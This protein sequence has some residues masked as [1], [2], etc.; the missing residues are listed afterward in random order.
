MAS[1]N[2]ALEWFIS[3]PLFS[4]DTAF[5]SPVPVMFTVPVAEIQLPVEDIEFTPFNSMSVEARSSMALLLFLLGDS[6]FTLLRV[7][8]FRLLSYDIVPDV[9]PSKALVLTLFI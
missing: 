8:F 5:M 4:V 9:R 1:L 3:T 6:S 7:S 2:L